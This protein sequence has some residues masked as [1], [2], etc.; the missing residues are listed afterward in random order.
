M[1]KYI[2]YLA[3]LSI[4]P[5]LL[6]GGGVG[7]PLRFLYYPI[8]LLLIRYFGSTA[9]FQSS[10]VFS[11]L[12]GLVPLTEGGGEY[13]AYEVAVNVLGFLLMGIAAG[14]I[15]D[16]MHQEVD[17][18]RRTSDTYHGLTNALNL[19]ITNLQSEMDSTSEA[20]ERLKELDKNKTHFLSSISH[21]IRSPL[22]SIRSFSEIILN[23]DDIGAET[24][25]EFLGI[26]NE[27]SERLTQLTNE[28]LDIVRMESGKTQWHMDTV[29]ISGVIRMAA[30]SM[31]PLAKNKGLSLKVSLPRDLTPVKGDR[32]RLLQVMLNFL[33][34]AVKFT[35]QGAIT[36]GAQD[37]PDAIKVY[38]SDTGEGIYP[39]ERDKIFEEFYRIGDSLTG[40]P[41]GAGL[42]LSISKK[43]IEAHG[44]SIW[45]ESQLGKGSTFYFT[46]PKKVEAVHEERVVSRFADVAG[47]QILVLEDNTAIRQILRETLEVLGY[48]TLGV[49]TV[50]AALETAKLRKPDAII[51]GYLDS[52]ERFGELRTFSR[53][54]GVPLY[55]VSIINDEKTGPQVAVNGYISRP[56]DKSNVEDVIKDVLRTSTGRI[57][58]ISAKPEEARDLQFFVGTKNYETAVVPDVG[59]IDFSKPMPDSI[60]IGG[61][62]KDEVYRSI[63][64][65]RN[66][67]RTRNIP[68]I[69]TLNIF[70]RDM[71]SIGLES[72]R[73]GGGL[74]R[75]L[76]KLEK[77]G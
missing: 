31:L 74:A 53:V 7:S 72:S 1:K 41:K 68:I 18:L 44:G 61:F 63:E 62:P 52:E 15:T 20:Y 34:N 46:L 21:E 57:L 65:L 64:I 13:P 51:F 70:L 42:G 40:R 29:E 55:L 8:L 43:I 11:I 37:G 27:E 47:R 6:I 9:I 22:S 24:R 16:S 28:I 54:Q 10:L 48:R 67:Q 4:I 2:V 76:Q 33:S 38:V 71:E 23:Y 60:I 75:M 58:I 25:K 59:S 14:Y 77:K 12:Y 69:L 66:N 32:N 49:S 17:S 56:F 3:L 73:Y 50:G 45:V 19:K 36:A 30:K 39:E 35:S 5:L 26:I